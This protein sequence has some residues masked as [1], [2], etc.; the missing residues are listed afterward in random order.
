MDACEIAECSHFVVVGLDERVRHGAGERDAEGAPRLD[1]RGRV[2][3][4]KV[5]GASR[6]Q[7]RFG[8]LRAAQA[9]VRKASGTGCEPTARRLARDQGLQ[10]EQVDEAALDEL[11]LGQ[12]RHDAQQ[13]LVCEADTAFG[14]GIH[15]AGEPHPREA[16]Q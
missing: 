2:E 13:R 3:A 6:E 11:R 12:R 4:G 14:H 9:E 5:A 15:V 16:L 7:A 1:G 8:T 10:V